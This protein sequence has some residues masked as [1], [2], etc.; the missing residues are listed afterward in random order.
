MIVVFAHTGGLVGA[1]IGVAGGTAVLAQR[2]LE[3]VFGDQAIRRLAKT[4]KDD[5][6]DRV[7]VLLADELVRYH[8][9]LDALAVEPDQSER[10]RDAAA[11][12]ELAR[13]SGLPVS[14]IDEAALPPGERR[15]AI[16]PPTVTQ[17]SS[18]EATD[19][20]DIVD[21]ELVDQPREELR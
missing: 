19:D 2:I 3:A 12:V 16:D 6:D 18:V 5:L 20:S 13:E 7:Q 11:A 9:V 8:K 4:A 15:L 14:E 17:V 21:A 10:L 1:E